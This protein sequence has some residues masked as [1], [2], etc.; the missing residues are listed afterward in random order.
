MIE[1]FQLCFY[2]GYITSEFIK[3]RKQNDTKTW[4]L[5]FWSSCTSQCRVITSRQPYDMID[6]YA[7]YRQINCC[8]NQQMDRCVQTKQTS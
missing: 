3:P 5:C 1:I 8:A 2:N 4:V 7:Q 6:R